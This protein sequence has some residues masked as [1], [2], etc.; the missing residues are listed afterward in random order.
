MSSA[1]DTSQGHLPNVSVSLIIVTNVGSFLQ[2]R[3]EF[4]VH[5]TNVSDINSILG[6][7]TSPD[8]M[9]SILVVQGYKNLCEPWCLG[10]WMA[11]DGQLRSIVQ[12]YLAPAGQQ[13]WLPRTPA[14]CQRITSAYWVRPVAQTRRKMDRVEKIQAAYGRAF[15]PQ[16][17]HGPSGSPQ[18]PNHHMYT[19]WPAERL[20]PSRILCRTE[21]E[22]L[23]CFAAEERVF[24][25]DCEGTDSPSKPGMLAGK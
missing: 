6:M 8:F 18:E 2:P 24:V 11:E 22:N 1:S 4:T 23:M 15:S 25:Y 9:A 3:Y 10:Q 20:Q 19:R 17:E 5:E 7:Q 12:Q 21:D 14:N 16:N 13:Y